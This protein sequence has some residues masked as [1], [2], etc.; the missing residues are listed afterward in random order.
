[1]FACFLREDVEDLVNWCR[2]LGP[3]G[4]WRRSSCIGSQCHRQYDVAMDLF[5][6]R[7]KKKAR[8][9]ESVDSL[10]ARIGAVDHKRFLCMKLLLQAVCSSLFLE[11]DSTKLL[12]VLDF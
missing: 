6:K 5:G 11:S 9:Q 3:L 2:N 1:M 4:W 12:S 7:R 10:P 8:E